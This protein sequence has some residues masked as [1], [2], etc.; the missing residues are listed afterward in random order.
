[1]KIKRFEAP[2]MTEALRMIKK[3]FGEEAVILSAKTTKKS[4]GV[5]G[6][7]RTKQVVVT[8]AIDMARLQPDALATPQE[9]RPTASDSPAGQGFR[10]TN[11]STAQMPRL[12][13]R[14]MPITRTGQQKLRSKFVHVAPESEKP[15]ESGIGREFRIRQHLEAQGLVSGLAEDLAEKTAALL[16][17]EPMGGEILQAL[18]QVIEAKGMIAPSGPGRRPGVK[19]RIMALVGPHGAGKTAT[20]AKLAAGALIHDRQ[21]AAL[22]TLDDQR[23]AGAT[24]LA[25]YAQIMGVDLHQPHD[26][27]QLREAV[28]SMSHADLIVVDTP[29]L[30][31][32]DPMGRTRLKSLLDD[33]HPTEVH[34]TL[35]ATAQGPVMR[36]VLDFFTPLGINRLLFTKIDWAENCGHLVNLIIDAHLPAT[37]LA[38]SPQVPEG[39]RPATAR[40]MASLIW[41][42]GRAAD[43]RMTVNLVQRRQPAQQSFEFVANRSS[44]I[45]HYK[46]CQSVKRINSENMVAFKDAA[47]AMGQN[48]K[49]CRMCCAQ[50][51]VSKPLDR[52]ASNRMASSR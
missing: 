1:M 49:P 33:L 7:K 18:S 46:D 45:F 16:P 10:A 19:P 48:F 43:D 21:N 14:F 50:L 22:L 23:I 47:D 35:D 38:D 25:R 13:Q 11:G 6:A 31:P 4:G 37:Y 3:E 24:E 28:Q 17:P 41:G 30:A 5:L 27:S 20:V 29:G 39:L 12:L 32:H 52:L 51:I 42:E 44:D 26:S 2:S 34:L 36:R 40:A 15:S 8:A 9:E